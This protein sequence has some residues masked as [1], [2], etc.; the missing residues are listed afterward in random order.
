[1]NRFLWL[2]CPKCGREAQVS[3]GAT[4]SINC[5]TCGWHALAREQR[6]RNAC[7]ADPC[8]NCI[9][10]PCHTSGATLS[11]SWLESET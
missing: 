2:D 10:G 7:V 8:L 4:V 3:A 9:G 6:Y 5:G 1:M 11:P